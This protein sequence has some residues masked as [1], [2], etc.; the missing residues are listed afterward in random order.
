MLFHVEPKTPFPAGGPIPHHYAHFPEPFMVLSMVAATTKTLRVSTWALLVPEHEPLAT[1]KRIAT[2]DG[3]SGGRLTLGVGAGW[4]REAPEPLGSD[5]PHGW[6]QAAGFVAATGRVGV[7]RVVE[8][9]AAEP[10]FEGDY[11]AKLY[12]LAR[13]ALP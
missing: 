2:P 13:M 10:L 7:N 9:S 4:L 3:L 1:A 5:F 8:V 11:L 6:T 12:R